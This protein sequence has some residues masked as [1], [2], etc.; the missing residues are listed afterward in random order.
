M[1]DVVTGSD[2]V[3]GLDELFPYPC[4]GLSVGEVTTG[5]PEIVPVP[6]LLEG[7]EE[8]VW[9]DATLAKELEPIIGDPIVAFAAPLPMEVLTDRPPDELPGCP[10]GLPGYR[11]GL[12][13]YPEEPPAVLLATPV[14]PEEPAEEP[15][16]ESTDEP[17]DVPAEAAVDDPVGLMALVAEDQTDEPLREPIGALEEGSEEDRADKPSEAPADGVE[18]EL[19][20]PADEPEALEPDKDVVWLSPAE[21]LGTIEDPPMITVLTETWV[22]TEVTVTTLLLHA[23]SVGREPEIL[24]VWLVAALVSVET[25]AVESSAE[26]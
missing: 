3:M 16:D 1:A 20:E 18:R 12:P 25:V 11:E 14:Q 17:V 26:D 23:V 19:K 15:A 24:F 6:P 21:A 2:V 7:Y 10:D 13:G 8:I 22:L 9:P 4:D 5:V